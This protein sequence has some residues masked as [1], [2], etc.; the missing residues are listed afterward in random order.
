MKKKKRFLGILIA[1]FVV[2]LIVHQTFHLSFFGTGISNFYEKGVSG[3]AI[4]KF[5]IG[6]ELKAKYKS[7]SPTSKIILIIEW[8]ILFTLVITAVIRNRIEIKKEIASIPNPNKYRKFQKSTDLDNLYN[9]LKEKKHLRLST[10]SK[11]FKVDKDLALNWAKTLESAELATISYPK[12][13]EP[14]ISLEE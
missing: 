6:E 3:F 7:V 11:V 1:I 4:G 5:S 14:E 2:I 9:L 10:I 13:G 8:A 12:F